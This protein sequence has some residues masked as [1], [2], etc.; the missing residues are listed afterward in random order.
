MICNF[1]VSQIWRPRLPWRDFIEARYLHELRWTYWASPDISKT[2]MTI[3]NQTP[4]IAIASACQLHT[5]MTMTRPV[6]LYHNALGAMEFAKSYPTLFSYRVNASV[7]SNNGTNILYTGK[8]WKHL[9]YEQ[10]LEQS[11]GT[12]PQFTRCRTVENTSMKVSSDLNLDHQPYQILQQ[13]GTDDKPPSA[14]IIHVTTNPST[15]L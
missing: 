15:P 13:H 8:Q 7:T 12:W 5:S 6:I 2:C 9:W 11:G 14:G 3:H 10:N 1:S 4:H